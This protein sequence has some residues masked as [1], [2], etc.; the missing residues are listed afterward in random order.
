MSIKE[1]VE[2]YKKTLELFPNDQE[3]YQYLIVLSKHVFTFPPT[4]QYCTEFPEYK[5]SIRRSWSKSKCFFHVY[6]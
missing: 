5:E 3:K 6:K 4:V 2:D 1:K